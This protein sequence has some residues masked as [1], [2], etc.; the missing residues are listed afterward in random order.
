MN[1]FK[2]KKGFALLYAIVMISVISVIAFGLANISFKQK[3]LSSLATDSQIAFYASDAGMECA[4]Y[5][6]QSIASASN[7]PCFDIDPTN[8]GQIVA[9]SKDPLLPIWKFSSSPRKETCFSVELGMPGVPPANPRPSFISK[10][11][12]TCQ[13]NQNRYVE[14]ILRAYF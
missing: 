3:L 9:M 2:N 10:G 14:R 1:Y 4:L 6:N 7:F 13:P 8:F 12:S 5:N 11:Y